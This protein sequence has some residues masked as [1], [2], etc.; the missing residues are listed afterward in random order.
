MGKKLAVSLIA[1]NFITSSAPD[2][3]DSLE[4]IIEVAIGVGTNSILR[5]FYDIII[6]IIA[7]CYFI[8]IFI[9]Y[10]Y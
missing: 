3:K 5:I 7:S 1:L 4:Y 6:F 2:P 8:L 9:C 10:V